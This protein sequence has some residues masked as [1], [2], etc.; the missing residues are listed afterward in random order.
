MR[1]LHI[2]AKFTRNRE[3]LKHI[4]KTFIRS[5]LE[6]S[7]TVW[8]SS[9]TLTDRQDLERIQK[10]AVKVILG[11][12]YNGYDEALGV[13]NLESLNRRRE[14]MALKFAKSSLKNDNF[15]KLFPLKEVKHG[16]LFRKSEKYS[17]NHSKTKRYKESAVPY[18]QG[19]LNRENLEKKQSLKRLIDV[20]ESSQSLRKRQRS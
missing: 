17:V 4:Y 16:M 9:L 1:M 13:L 3:H 5:N 12:E 7:S 2:A 15:S 6:F 11:K 19:L 10:A 8:H 14:V 18:L 20:C